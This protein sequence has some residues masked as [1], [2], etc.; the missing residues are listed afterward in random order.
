MPSPEQ[1]ARIRQL[2]EQIAALRRTLA[3]P[4]P[5]LDADQVAWEESLLADPK[6]AEKLPAKIA[7]ILKLESAERA[8]AERE[9]IAAYYRSDVAPRLA[10]TRDD[11]AD[12][13]R[14]KAEVD[15]AIPR[16]L[17]ATSVA[18]RVIRILPRGNWL[19]E[20]GPIVTPAVPAFLAPGASEG[21]RATRLD[22]AR[23]LVD[24]DNPLVARVFVNRLWKL[25]FGQ[26]LVATLDDF[27][28]QGARPTHPELLD[29]LAT[30]F[31]DRGWEVKRMLR[32]MVLSGTYR[33][34]SR[35]DEPT[36]QR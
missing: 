25:A 30:E 18:P 33:Q 34:S 4:T 21:R 24:R 23:W 19:D 32:L 31:M 8:D 13:E 22:L 11:L 6:E 10:A 12:R 3:T 36:R 28:A 1:A 16:T 17:I 15:R 7:R 5:E 20:S 14:R 2:D 35:A 29:W 9:E 27:G 26:G